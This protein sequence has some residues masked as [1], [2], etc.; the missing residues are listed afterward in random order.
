MVAVGVALHLPMFWMGRKTGYRL[1][2]MPMDNGMIIGMALTIAGMLGAAYGL[3]PRRRPEQASFGSITPT[4]DVPLTKAHWIQIALV[5][6][7]LVID[8]MKAASL[9]FVTPG[10]RIEYG[11]S[12]N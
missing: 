6:I 12:K 2:G 3:M 8:V 4:E 5:G 7:A 1:V 9:G 10:M 11:V